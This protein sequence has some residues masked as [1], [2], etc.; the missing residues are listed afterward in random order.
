M[1]FLL[2]LVYPFTIIID[3]GHGGKDPGAI[4]DGIKEKDINLKVA[5]FLKNIIERKVKGVNVV[6]TRDKDIF[7][8][9][10]ER[11]VIANKY[12][13]DD[14]V[15]I[16]I[17][18]NSHDKNN[19]AKGIEIYYFDN[20]SEKIIKE[21][22]GLI[23][24]KLNYCYRDTIRNVLNKVVNSKLVLDS[25]RLAENVAEGIKNL[26]VNIRFIKPANFFVSSYV[27]NP[28]ILIEV[29]FITEY[30][31]KKDSYLHNISTGIVIGILSYYKKNRFF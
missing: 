7:L 9:L 19:N 12:S 8:S 21:R 25:K 4:K 18:T 23:D 24:Q 13:D 31:L 26:P 5:F 22:I 17:H 6:L 11:V 16:S 1:F 20:T 14:A 2:N 29:G 27:L 30:D 15:F 28:S 3:P 10:Q